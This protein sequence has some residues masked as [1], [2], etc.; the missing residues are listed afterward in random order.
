MEPIKTRNTFQ[1]ND[2]YDDEEIQERVVELRDGGKSWDDITEI[3]RKEISEPNMHES[4]TRVL[5]NR[6]MAKTISIEKRGGQ[7]FKDY[8]DELGRMYGKSIK[9]LEGYITAA[10]K[11]SEELVGMIGEGDMTAVKAYGIILKTAPQM[12]SITSEI[13]DFMRLQQD[14]QD[15]IKIEQSAMIWNESQMIDYLNKYI[16]KLAKEK[17]IKILQPNI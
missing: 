4:T 7:K 15:K 11:V 10:E 12:K 13:R 9:V 14:Q 16:K 17:K 1:R 5:Y 3:V 6:A 8:S 2:K